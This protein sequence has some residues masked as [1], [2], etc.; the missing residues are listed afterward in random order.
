MSIQSVQDFMVRV[1]QDPGLQQELAV[2]LEADNDRE[3]ATQLA[4]KH[5]YTFTQDELWQAVQEAQ[6]SVQDRQKGGQL[7]LTDEELEAVAGGEV[8]MLSAATLAVTIASANLAAG[9][10]A[11]TITIG[12]SAIRV[13][14]PKW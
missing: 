1:S 13:P 9:S 8:I 12:V 10:A 11:V 4:A 5:G 14:R 2:A 7:E 6:A 3:A